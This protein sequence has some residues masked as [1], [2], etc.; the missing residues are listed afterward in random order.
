MRT[1]AELLE[2]R[3]MLAS[4]DGNYWSDMP[5]EWVA[6]TTDATPADAEWFR[7]LGAVEE[8]GLLSIGNLFHDDSDGTWDLMNL[9]SDYWPLWRGTIP[10]RG[11]VVCLLVAIAETPKGTA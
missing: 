9:R 11:Q 10:T 4:P 3:A 8:H 2:T 7:E 5:R 6:D 1:L